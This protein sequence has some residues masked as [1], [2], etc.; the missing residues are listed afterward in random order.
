YSY[1]SKSK[2]FSCISS[3]V[4]RIKNIDN[5]CAVLEL[6][7][8][9]SDH[10]HSSHSKKCCNCRPHKIESPCDQLNHK[11]VEKL[12]GTG[13]CINVDLSSFTAITCLPPIYLPPCTC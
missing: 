9:K 11:D 2:K 13:V 6:L 12:I 10:K 1:H 8:F 5:N 7:T 4:F 3:F